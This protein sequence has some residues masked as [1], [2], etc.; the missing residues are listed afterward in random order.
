VHDDRKPLLPGAVSRDAGR[1]TRP[2][3]TRD[4]ALGLAIVC[5]RVGVAATRLAL[6]PLRLAAQAPVVGPLLE[7]TGDSLADAGRAARTQGRGR[8]ETAAGDAFSSP[9]AGRAVDHALA[10]PLPEAIARSLIERHVVQRIAEQV[11]ASAEL[12]PAPG[13]P[14]TETTGDAAV[15][16]LVA[17]ALESRVVSDVTDQ[18]IESPEI[19]RMIEE[20]ASSPAVRTALSRQ[21]TTFAE[22][23]AAGLRHRMESLDDAVERTVHR[24]LRR[25]ARPAAVQSPRPAYGGLSTRATAFAIDLGITLV[26]FLVGAALAALVSDLVGG[27]RPSWLAEALAIV[28]WTTVV[29][30]YLVAFW[31]VAG[32]TPGMRVMRL[33]ITDHRRMPPNL[34]R[35]LLRLVGLWL[36]IVPFFAGFLPVLVDDRRRALQDFMAGTV[37][38]SED[39]PVVADRA[40][41]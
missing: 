34:G 20:I 36:A 32:E 38:R 21:T 19:Q 5:G 11:L 40:S 23:T 12:Q 2:T 3:D 30:V 9:E 31:T 6:I 7:R 29:N 14:L 37:V 39:A 22:E 13:G 8:L 35:S 27:F 16:R 25:K 28:G 17:G 10:G 41:G 26:I 24:L 18:V 1:V 4:T 33:Q 15:E